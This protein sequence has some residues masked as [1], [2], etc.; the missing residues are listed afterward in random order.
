M[1][2]VKA[3]LRAVGLLLHGF[4]RGVGLVIIFL[5]LLGVAGYFTLKTMF[6]EEHVK[7]VIVEQIQSVTRRPVQLDGFVLTLHGIKLRGI[8]VL[9][10]PGAPGDL[11]R[12]DFAVATVKLWPLLQRRIELHNVKLV[13]PRITLDRDEA[14]HWNVADFFTSPSTSTVVPIS[15]PSTLAAE[16]IE[17]ENGTVSVH[18]GSAGR[19]F[20]FDKV[21]LSLRDFNLDHPFAYALSFNNVNALRNQAVST[22]WSSEGSLFLAGLDATKVALKA[23]ELKVSVDGNVFSGK[24][25][26]KG[27]PRPRLECELRAPAVGP[28]Q[29]GRYLRPP[30]NFSLPPSRW[31]A[32]VA[33]PE[34]RKIQFDRVHVSA[35]PLSLT[36]SGGI[37]LDA[38]R[39]W[40]DL[41]LDELPLE[42]GASM[43]P[44]L[45]PY[46]LKGR[47][48][49]DV[50]V[51]GWFERLQI[52]RLR[53]IVRDLEGVFKHFRVARGNISAIVSDDF[54]RAGIGVAGGAVEAFG[55][56]FTDVALSMS[57][58]NKDLKVDN[59]DLKWAGAPLK[60][61]A[62]VRDVTDPKEVVIS[63]RLDRLR[64]ED[65]QGLVGRVME[66]WSAVSPGTAAPAPAAKTP[67]V[68][69]FKYVIPRKFPDTIGHISIG[70]IIHQYLDCDNLDV[71]WDIRGVSPSLKYLSG[72]LKVGFGPGRVNDIPAVQ[73][74]NKILK[75]VFLPFV[76]MHKMNNLA[77]LSP[78]TAYPKTLDF[79]R[80]EGE[81]SLSR[82]VATTRYFSV[83]SPQL[84]AYADGTAD[85]GKEKVDMHILT[86][87]TSYR[88]QLPEWWVD[89]LGRPAI[90]FRVKGDLNDPTLEPRLNKM[91]ANE[92]EKRKEEGRERSA[93]GAAGKMRDL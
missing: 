31:S 32:T 86:R 25:S 72:E 56:S 75:V 7:S 38:S 5:I 68:R 82:G 11:L 88:S 27:F 3:V 37:D 15:L 39:L 70:K 14:G 9:N 45:A 33:W 30:P 80:I 48:E 44:I 20:R 87:L 63:G 46:H 61:K 4:F 16:R 43:L 6:K 67:W 51:S 58:V 1:K 8:R 41:K 78:S 2:V 19:R 79:T 50:S 71:V 24:V 81:Y 17:I 35:K 18:D 69:T 89:E 40:A 93:L 52:H 59:L 57:L 10:L 90:G 36:A 85:F 92:I 76:Y 73:K 21:N 83:E 29:L 34:P 64:W 66:E 60:L 62:R 49:G 74:T 91:A 54:A 65:A 26:V 55:N 84:V 13:A 28:S 23:D 22:S 12:G 42:A 77:V 53:W 47:G